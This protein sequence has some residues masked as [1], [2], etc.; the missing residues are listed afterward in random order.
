MCAHHWGSTH[1]YYQKRR[2][3][4]VILG[5]EIVTGTALTPVTWGSYWDYFG[6]RLV[7]L[8]GVTEGVAVLD[9]G[10]GGGA[11]LYPAA[12]IV[13][14]RGQVIGIETCRHCQERTSSEIKRCG[15]TNAKVLLMNAE[16]MTFTDS[17]FDIVIAG[18]IGWD[19]CYDFESCKFKKRDKKL[20][21]ILRSPETRR[22]SWFHWLDLTRRWRLDG[23]AGSQVS[24]IRFV[25]G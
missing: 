10:T 11:S 22:Q 23:R 4:Q 14:D 6:R 25:K 12:R 16:D 1:T 15:I 8:V 20:E 19:D 2:P 18:L 21:E 24:S 17:S 3:V 9:I 13:G 7:E 5:A